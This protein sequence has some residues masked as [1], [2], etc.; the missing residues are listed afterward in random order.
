MSRPKNG[1]LK[2]NA[3]A[4]E[5]IKPFAIKHYNFYPCSYLES[6]QQGYIYFLFVKYR[7]NRFPVPELESPRFKS[8]KEA[9]NFV[10]NNNFTKYVIG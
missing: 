6:K 9:E 7:R 4:A 8:R 1:K 5:K 10:N 2:P 3:I